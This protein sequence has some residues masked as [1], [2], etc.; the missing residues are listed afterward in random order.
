M[1]KIAQQK[2]IHNTRGRIEIKI[3]QRLKKQGELEGKSKYEIK[4]IISSLLD[5]QDP[6]PQLEESKE[7]IVQNNLVDEVMELKQRI[8]TIDTKLEESIELSKNIL[9]S[10]RMSGSVLR[11]P[12]LRHNSNISQ[13]R[14]PDLIPEHS[15][16]DYDSEQILQEMNSAQGT[17]D[18][19]YKYKF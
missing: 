2:D 7:E 11:N 13:I 17:I 15:S 4:E 19:A 9:E 8:T 10:V 5:K 1:K 18:T 14:M 3:L 16:E 12:P 6:E